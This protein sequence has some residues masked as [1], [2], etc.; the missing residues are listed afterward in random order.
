M[1]ASDLESPDVAQSS[2][3]ADF[4]HSFQVFSHL[5][6]PSIGNEDK[7][8]AFLSVSLSVV[9]PCRNVVAYIFI[10]IYSIPCGSATISLSRLTSSWVSSPALFVGSILATLSST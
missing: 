4:S 3:E 5:G 1:L 8:L 2:M 10:D 6:V 9:Q 7:V